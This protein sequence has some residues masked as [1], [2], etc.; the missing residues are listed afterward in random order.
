MQ[1][2][3]KI[4]S[5]LRKLAIPYDSQHPPV[6]PRPTSVV[7]A[8]V[9]PFTSDPTANLTNYY[10]MPRFKI[11]YQNEVEFSRELQFLCDQAD[12]KADRMYSFRSVVP[13]LS[14]MNELSL[15]TS[16]KQQLKQ[17]E[18][19]VIEQRVAEHIA[20]FQFCADA[21]NTLIRICEHLIK[22][23]PKNAFC[24]DVLMFELMKGLDKLILLN[25]VKNRKSAPKNE[26]SYR[27][28]LKPYMTNPDPNVDGFM[29]SNEHVMINFFGTPNS[30]I[31]SFIRKIRDIPGSYLFFVHFCNE[32][33]DYFEKGYFLTSNEKHMLIRVM[34]LGMSLIDG[35]FKLPDKER[36]KLYTGQ[37]AQVDKNKKINVY[38]K[39]NLNIDGLKTILTRYPHVPLVFELSISPQK[40][41]RDNNICP[42]PFPTDEW[43]DDTSFINERYDIVK[44]QSELEFQ[45][46]AT[47]ARLAYAERVKVPTHFPRSGKSIA[48]CTT[49]S[50]ALGGGAGTTM[51]SFSGGAQKPVDVLRVDSEFASNVFFESLTLLSQ[52]SHYLA[53]FMARKY[54]N[55]SNNVICNEI[56]DEELKMYSIPRRARIKANLNTISTFERSVRYNFRRHERT[57]FALLVIAQRNLASRLRRCIPTFL[58]CIHRT[59]FFEIQTCCQYTSRRVIQKAIKNK[60]NDIVNRLLM[61]REVAA[62]WHQGN[63]PANDPIL[64]GKDEKTFVPPP[65]PLLVVPP[66]QTQLFVFRSLISSISSPRSPAFVHSKF[67]SAEIDKEDQAVL[68]HFMQRSFMTRYLYALPDTVNVLDDLGYLWYRE[69]FVERGHTTEKQDQY[70]LD[71]SPP[72]IFTHQILTVEP[73]HIDQLMC[74][75]STYSDAAK[76]ALNR[77][78]SQSL[79]LEIVGEA[80]LALNLL[81]NEL[82]EKIFEHAKRTVV[83]QD[84][85]SDFRLLVE[86]DSK[87]SKGGTALKMEG[88]DDQ[89]LRKTSTKRLN[90]PKTLT[91]YFPYGPILEMHDVEFVGYR[92]DFGE[93]VS[94][95]VEEMLIENTKQAVLCMGQTETV[96][97]GSRLMDTLHKCYSW[98]DNFI[99]FSNPWSLI[100]ETANGSGVIT[101]HSSQATYSALTIILTILAP[102]WKFNVESFDFRLKGKP[103]THKVMLDRM[104]TLFRQA[105]T[106][107]Q[108]FTTY[109]NTIYA[110][111]FA[112][113]SQ[114]F[115]TIPH[116]SNLVKMMPKT[117]LIATFNNLNDALES[118]IKEALSLVKSH[119]LLLPFYAMKEMP[120]DATGEQFIQYFS[121]TRVGLATKRAGVMEL[122]DAFARVGNIL[123]AIVQLDSACVVQDSQSVIHN[124]AASAY[125]LNAAF[126]NTK[127]VISQAQRIAEGSPIQAH[128]IAV[129]ALSTPEFNH[130]LHAALTWT[131]IVNHSFFANTLSRL[132]NYLT[133]LQ[134]EFPGLLQPHSLSTFVPPPPTSIADVDAFPSYQRPD[135][136]IMSDLDLPFLNTPSVHAKTLSEVCAGVI[137]V[138]AVSMAQETLKRMEDADKKNPPKGPELHKNPLELDVWAEHGDGLWLG[139]ATLIHLS[140]QSETFAGITPE[141][142][143]EIEKL[144][145]KKGGSIQ[146]TVQVYLNSIKSIHE[147]LSTCFRLVRSA[148]T[149]FPFHRKSVELS[150]AQTVDWMAHNHPSDFAKLLANAADLIGPCRSGRYD[151]ESTQPVRPP[152]STSPQFASSASPQGQSSGEPQ[153]PPPAPLGD[154]GSLPPPPPMDS[155]NVPPPPAMDGGSVPPPPPIGGG[156]VPP[157]PPMGGGSVPPP[158]PIGG[159]S[160]PP[161][162]PMGGGNVPPPPPMGGGSV[163]PP[164]PMGG[165]MPPPPPPDGGFGDLPP[166]PPGD[167]GDLPPPPPADF[168][169]LPPP[170]PK[171]SKLKKWGQ[172]QTSL[173]LSLGIIVLGIVQFSLPIYQ[174]LS[175]S[176]KSLSS[177]GSFYLWTVITGSF[178]SPTIIELLCCLLVLIPM[179]FHFESKWSAFQM[180]R[181][182]LAVAITTNLIVFLLAAFIGGACRVKAIFQSDYSGLYPIIVA[183]VLAFRQEQMDTPLFPC[184]SPLRK[185][186]IKYLPFTLKLLSI[187]L[188]F[189]PTR[190]GFFLTIYVST[191]VSWGYLRFKLKPKLSASGLPVLETDNQSIDSRFPL[192]F[193]FTS[194]YPPFMKWFS[195]PL[196]KFA[197]KLL[198]LFPNRLGK[199]FTNEKYVNFVKGSH[200]LPSPTHLMPENDALDELDLNL[201]SLQTNE[202][203]QSST[204][205]PAS[206]LPQPPV[207]ADL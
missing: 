47:L 132:F 56:D 139:M 32:A 63:P 131:N 128:Q 99:Q 29:K 86:G 187:P 94:E 117:E 172:H 192:D 177:G 159:G 123:A 78:R 129:S 67:S 145:A 142:I 74:V 156:S 116:M 49:A 19:R 27:N 188:S 2:A 165:F 18:V 118:F 96:T 82:S 85:E 102:S 77:F 71:S 195:L 101:T 46:C 191:Q 68:A 50:N 115:S 199:F 93:I 31:C 163:P 189:I 169:D 16:T 25:E 61:I 69:E 3:D 108:L 126:P 171:V 134:G 88:T 20:F 58:P 107:E 114:I 178:V 57:A 36:D 146:T 112:F 21:T 150:Q 198:R 100:S 201:P 148:F 87:R 24:S 79:Y 186:T 138:C 147:T 106:S 92:I 38:K 42:S 4:T 182:I 8:L 207:L 161:P 133:S 80:R 81:V 5:D 14:I 26:I 122:T 179:M 185:L 119:T 184:F 181:L 124:T 89:T 73:K 136:T 193:S 43:K 10:D 162:P 55:F 30:I 168:G 28:T 206:F 154:T 164:P 52:I 13:A 70:P 37:L 75:F 109:Y 59:S 196:S 1:E 153:L 194:L 83:G 167:F 155:G 127:Q 152:P 204:D 157:P 91:R 22:L 113:N 62:C 183:Y 120:L 95:R 144:V 105:F 197:D 44:Y 34:G 54:L 121:P 9:R 205:A 135:G 176:L 66:H 23:N 175:F 166:P 39:G 180:I 6:E 97:V 64:K 45:L 84:L 190:H 53:E 103:N 203:L 41:L 137:D 202:S 151:Y 125:S 158:P 170:P 12:S 173:F 40:Y 174:Y 130:L 72:W 104:K 143:L 149:L 90:M 65:I 17:E 98:L 51:E 11:Q 48:D 33:V 110:N 160:V 7:D 200:L 111:Q 60:K 35:C 140:G 76:I 141:N 15:D